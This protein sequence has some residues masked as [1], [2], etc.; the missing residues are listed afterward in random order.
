MP[1]MVAF[2]LG[3]AIRLAMES[4]LLVADTM[5]AKGPFPHYETDRI[6]NEQ[7]NIFNGTYIF[8]QTDNCVLS[9]ALIHMSTILCR[10]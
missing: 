5:R 10:V 9:S 7:F 4:V 6:T 3:L 2:A 1:E 8:W